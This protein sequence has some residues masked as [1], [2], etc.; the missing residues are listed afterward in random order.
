MNAD[1]FRAIR[2]YLNLTQEEFAKMLG[3]SLATVGRI[4]NGSLDITP[5]VKAK[6]ASKIELTDDFFTFYEKMRKIS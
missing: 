6:I 3:V 1:K 2:L 4:E 5:R